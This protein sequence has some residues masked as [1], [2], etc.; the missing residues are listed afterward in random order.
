MGKR[1]PNQVQSRTFPPADRMQDYG[2]QPLT[3][4]DLLKED[5]TT[6]P[7]KHPLLRPNASSQV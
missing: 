4:Q 3:V 2:I 1:T 5:D 6:D 7:W